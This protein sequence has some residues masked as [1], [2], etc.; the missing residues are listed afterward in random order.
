MSPR[1]SRPAVVLA[2]ALVASATT[3]TAQAQPS[4]VTDPTSL[5]NH[6]IG[7]GSG[8]EHVGSVNT[9][10]GAVAPF[11]MLSWSPETTSRPAG[12]GY[13]HRDNA[14]IGL[15]VT[16]LSGVGCPVQGDLPILPTVGEVTGE[17][18]RATQ[19]FSHADEKASPGL[20]ETR[21]GGAI[22]ARVAAT[23]RTGVGRF[24]FPAAEKA[25]LLFKAG[26]SQVA[27]S[28]VQVR[29][30]GPD[31][32]AGTITGGRFC[33]Q[34]NTSTVHFAAVFDRPFTGTGTWHDDVLT[35]GGTAVDHPR[36]GAWVTFDTRQQRQVGV[37]VAISYVSQAGALANLRAEA[38]G[39]DVDGVA[40]QTRAAWHRLLS[41]I[42]V[43]G[44]T[45]DRQAQFYTALYHS[46]LH[47]NVFSDVDGRYTGFDRQVHT[48]NR[49]RYA[50][51]SGWDTY[52]TLVQLQAVL[53][54]AE[55]SA[56]MQ[57]LVDMAAEGGWLPKWPVANGYTG[58]MNGDAAAALISSAH[59]FGARDF[60]T[61]A[62]LAAV[63]KGAT[64]V[65]TPA[66][67]GQGWYEQRPGL[68]E[69]LRD[70][71]VRNTRAFDISHV[72]NGAS[73]TLE[74]ALAD[75]GISRFA[76]ALGDEA[77]ART[78]LTRSQNWTTLFN[79]GSGFL[80]PRDANGAFPA[81]NPVTTG[82][83]VFGQSGFQEGNAAQ[84]LWL[85]PHNARGLLDAIGGDER[86]VARLDRFF[87]QDNA[88][89]N[90]P[91]Y[92]AGNEVNMHVPYLY[93]YAGT[94][95]RTQEVV[96]RTLE[97]RYANTP[98]GEPGNDDLGALSSWYV[99]SAMGLYPATPGTDVL[100]VT[101]PLFPSVR[102]DL[103]G[104]RTT[105]TSTGSGAYVRGLSVD[106]VATQ[107]TWLP[108][109]ALLGDGPGG[110]TGTALTFALTGQPDRSWGTSRDARP[111]SFPAGA[112]AFPPGVT[113]VELTTT[114]ARPT[115]AVGSPS[116]AA[117][118]FAVGVG[119][120]PAT[121][122][123]VRSV[124]WRATPPAGVTV[125]PAEGTAQVV[126]GVATAQ[127]ALQA[128]EGV[129]QGFTTIPVTLTADVA[130]SPVSVPV[131][132]VGAGPAARVCGVLGTTNQARGI[133]HIESGGDGVTTPVTVGGREA[134]RMV[135]RVPG[136][137]HM[138]F[139]VDQRIASDG[140]FPTTF[141]VDYLDE[142][143]HSWSLQYDSRDGGAY[144]H[145][146]SVANTGAGTWKTATFTVPDAALAHRQNERADFRLASASPV[147]VHRV[148]AVVDGPGVLPMDL[149]G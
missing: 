1:R 92:W 35:P 117:L 101:S 83:G 24:A 11:G 148:T 78:F 118:S 88:G 70:G 144:R 40:R 3:A 51:F 95:W 28:A 22:T 38:P 39:W 89:P 45:R 19:P 73:A 79:R 43:G 48:S 120:E 74:Y 7:T 23:T 85:V 137:L 142:G 80:Q 111:P 29:V 124:S 49:V 149:C 46:L 138:Y 115:V 106:G 127:V 77:T 68:A 139:S 108:G 100:T 136:G 126:D 125:T 20:F 94:P 33:D 147:T 31:Q 18:A 105:I 134:R 21:L 16:H 32:L 6:F 50:N 37:K 2:L 44:G 113:P 5:V 141:T 90:N 10:P 140:R 61:R 114:P 133:T 13:D 27:N 52:R 128:A 86:A 62:A 82:M 121:P 64:R 96:R 69:Y 119:A 47:P 103:P 30:T 17:P 98:G 130:L 36:G 112:P 63:V 42:Q 93:N 54:P 41:K 55:T 107:R 15:S 109:S 87:T 72:P 116:T 81:G 60:D 14:T 67:L 97:T 76:A 26:S 84:Y 57:S 25:N 135:E 146:G 56:M 8:G 132:V 65:P 12:G 34:P 102:I 129:V 131:A 66:E 110:R 104:H 91:F 122:V 9:F 75:F 4:P 145:A 99:W 71:Y 143:T 58:V 53:A 59:A 123:S